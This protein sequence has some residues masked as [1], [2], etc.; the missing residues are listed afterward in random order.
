MSPIDRLLNDL[1]LVF[2]SRLMSLVVYGRHAV[3]EASPQPVH[4]L[5]LVDG[6][7]MHDLEGCAQQARGWQAAGLAVP[8]MVSRHEFA[9]SLDVFPFEFGAIIDAHRVV[10]GADPFDGLRVKVEDIRRACE[11]DVKGHLLHLRESYVESY[12]DPDAIAALVNASAAALRTLASNTIVEY[13]VLAIEL[14]QFSEWQREIIR[15]GRAPFGAL[16][17]R[18]EI[19]FVSTP[20]GFFALSG[21]HLAATPLATPTDVTCHGRFNRLARE[22]G[23]P[24]AWI[25]EILPPA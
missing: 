12:G 13:G 19:P 25:L 10:H 11:I 22:S 4:T 1:H 20:I 8:L 3:D 7:S 14:A 16:L 23:E 17:H 2:G 9:R 6:L 21:R 15:A 5:A 24:L 18:F